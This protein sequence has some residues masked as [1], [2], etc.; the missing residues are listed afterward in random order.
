MASSEYLFEP[1]DLPPVIRYEKLFENL[2][3]QTAVTNP[4]SPKVPRMHALVSWYTMV[5]PF[6]KKIHLMIFRI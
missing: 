1:A 3:L 5:K 6:Q 2:P 4:D